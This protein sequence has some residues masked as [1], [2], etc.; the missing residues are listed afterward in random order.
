PVDYGLLVLRTPRLFVEAK[1]LGENLDDRR[2][3]NQIMGYAGVAGVQWIV[4][5]DG[6]EYRI[7]NTHAPVSVE[8]KLFRTVRVTDDHALVHETLELLAKDRMEENRIEVLWRAHFVD[9]HVRAAIEQ[10][11]AGE[12]DL[13]LVN[14]VAQHTKNLTAE[15]IRSSLKRC[16]VALDFPLPT[17]ELLRQPAAKEPRAKR[18]PTGERS[19]VTLQDLIQAGL[20][21][22]PVALERDYKGKR[23]T[24]RIGPD[25]TVTCLGKSYDSLSM[26][27]A[28]A[29]HSV[30]QVRAD[31]KPPATNGWTFW[32]LRDTSGELV[33]VDAIRRRF[34]EG[35][36]GGSTSK[37]AT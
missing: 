7:Y 24:A 2:W 3:T 20:L 30:A 29:R 8:E 26:T 23:L 21:R 32:K 14:Y 33:E 28:V 37:A 10:L 35:G 36:R 4:L 1:A 6:N 12:G 17:E 31:G 27:G 16:R 19:E 11:F 22:P 9:R 13:L 25:G 15:E 5:T 18:E 34:L